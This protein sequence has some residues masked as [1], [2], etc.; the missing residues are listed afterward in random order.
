MAQKLRPRLSPMLLSQRTGP[1]SQRRR[2]GG[3]LIDSSS[4]PMS[5]GCY[6]FHLVEVAVLAKSSGT[7]H[8]LDC[9]A[10]SAGM[11]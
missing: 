2:F 10:A 11:S 6:V 5:H 8:G 1:I 7:L 3:A 4:K 9:G